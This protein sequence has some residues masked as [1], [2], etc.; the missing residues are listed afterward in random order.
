MVPMRAASA[1][2]ALTAIATALP[3]QVTPIN[4]PTGVAT[5]TSLPLPFNAPQCRFQQWYSAADWQAVQNGPGRVVSATF[6]A[7]NS[8]SVTTQLDV[9]VRM[10]HGPSAPSGLFDNNL[11]SDTLI[12]VSRKNVQLTAGVGITFNFD[13]PFT[14]DAT[15]PVVIEVRIYGNTFGVGNQGFTDEFLCSSL[16]FG[17]TA[18]LYNTTSASASFATIENGVGLL[19]R[20]GILPG[21]AVPFGS[22]CPGDGGFTPVHTVLGYPRPGQPY[23][24]ELA[25]APSQKF[26][27]LA[28]GLSKDMWAGQP[29][30]M[31][32][33]APLGAYLG[34]TGCD[35]LVEPRLMWSKFTVGGGPGTGVASHSEI[36][37]PLNDIIGT[38]I[39]TQWVIFDKNSPNGHLTASN[40][41]VGIVGP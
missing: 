39:Y 40:A 25:N 10:A 23:Q 41:V 36:M 26:T 21:A 19:T 17:K 5:T 33:K 22:G 4:L 12:V 8:S 6:F 3:A 15:S 38:A 32:L 34:G 18:R 7:G 29:L 16:S 31:S 13:N 1:L 35:L 24:A 20:F 28:G 27:I 11:A 37:P 14:W 9:E 30:P 2:L